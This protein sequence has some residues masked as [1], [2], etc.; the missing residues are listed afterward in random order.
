MPATYVPGPNGPIVLASGVPTTTWDPVN[1]ASGIALSGGNLIATRA[2]GGRAHT[3]SLASH[4]SGKYYMEVTAT[5]ASSG[6][7]A[8]G[9]LNGSETFARYIGE[10]GNNSLGYWSDA[11]VYRNGSVVATLATWATGDVISMAVDV[12]ASRIWFR[13]NAGNWNNNPAADPAAATNGIDISAI[14]GALFSGNELQADTNVGTANFGASAYAQ[15]VPS[16]FG[17]W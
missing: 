5:S 8:V 11:S 14:T 4:S 6:F 1:I 7:D 3:R 16:G 9:V 17:N 10:G 12:G 13:K 2:G 15:S